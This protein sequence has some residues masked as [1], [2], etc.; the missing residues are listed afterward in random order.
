MPGAEDAA[1]PNSSGYD[2]HA[3]YATEQPP[4]TKNVSMARLHRHNPGPGVVFFRVRSDRDT[5]LD[6]FSLL[7]LHPAVVF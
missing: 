3:K 4:V 1:D 2:Q 7:L 5:V 6:M